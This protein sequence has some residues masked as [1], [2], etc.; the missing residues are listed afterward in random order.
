MKQRDG[1]RNRISWL[2]AKDILFPDF[3]FPLK[4]LGSLAQVCRES[5]PLTHVMLLTNLLIPHPHAS[6]F[7]T[8]PTLGQGSVA[9][10]AAG[11]YLFLG[12]AFEGKDGYGRGLLTS[13]ELGGH[14]KKEMC[15]EPKER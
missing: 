7:S 14:G 9:K 5:T 2:D 13:A 8:F 11:L 4:G 10:Y 12:L 6:Y 3:R 15:S 1:I